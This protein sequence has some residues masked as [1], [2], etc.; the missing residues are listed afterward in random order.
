VV[1]WSESVRQSSEER[2][3]VSIQTTQTCLGGHCKADET[4][5]CREGA[6]NLRMGDDPMISIGGLE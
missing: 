5:T 4:R 1:S 6:F 3:G 2:F